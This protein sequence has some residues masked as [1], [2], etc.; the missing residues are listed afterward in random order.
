MAKLKILIVGTLSGTVG[1][2]TVSLT[3]L[4]S[5]ISNCEN[6][7]S[8]LINTAGIRGG[9][10]LKYLKLQF[11]FFRAV[12]RNDVVSVHIAEAA[13]PYLL[14]WAYLFTRMFRKPCIL[15]VFGGRGYQGL[16]GWRRALGVFFARKVHLYLAQTKDI[17]ERAITDGFT[18]VRW[19]PTSRPTNAK[20]DVVNL[21][22]MRH[23]R[24]FRYVFLSR[25]VPSK[26]IRELIEAG[27]GADGLLEIDVYGPLGDGISEKDFDSVKNV[28]YRGVCESV[29]VPQILREHDALLL[30][31]YWEDEGYPGAIIEAFTAGLPIVSTVWKS[32]P[33][34]VDSSCGILVPPRDVDAL[35]AALKKL[36][37]DRK[38]W[39]EMVDGSFRR[40]KEFCAEVW[41]ERFVDYCLALASRK[42]PPV[43]LWK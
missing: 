8:E 1:G 20:V 6:A 29:E 3:H 21:P 13:M 42:K 32:I 36:A 14:P 2:T 15:R 34:L 40:S 31:T 30:P 39:Q 41:C 43:Y 28:H 9:G 10:I 18:C 27:S 17:Y 7:K 11:E 38:L 24:V 22:A 16:K 37:S 4:A 5:E 35:L 12:R 23:D 26:G 33:E 25:V 19:F